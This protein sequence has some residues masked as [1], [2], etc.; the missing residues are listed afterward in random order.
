MKTTALST[1]DGPVSAPTYGRSIAALIGFFCLTFLAPLAS[2][3][4]DPRA[5]YPALAKPAWA[6]LGWIFGPVWTLLSAL[7]AIAAWGVWKRR[8]CPTDRGSR[9]ENRR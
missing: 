7:M 6:P 1:S 2:A 4:I 5:W 9:S 3:W 8:G